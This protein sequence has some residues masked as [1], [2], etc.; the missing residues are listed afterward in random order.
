MTWRFPVARLVGRLIR[1]LA[2]T[3]GLGGTSLPGRVILGIDPDFIKHTIRQFDLVILITGTNGKTTTANLVAEI[4]RRHGDEVIH[5]R[6]GA[7]MLSG[8]ATALLDRPRRKSGR[9]VAV[10]EVDEGNLDLLCQHL[11]PSAVV[12]TNL[13]RDQ[14]DRYWEL[15]RLWQV[16]HDCLLSLPEATL[17]LNADDS[18]VASLGYGHQRVQYY[19][20]NQKPEQKSSIIEPREAHFCPLC[21]APLRFEYF[22]YSHLGQYACTACAY[23][24]PEPNY[25]VI[26]YYIQAGTTSFKLRHP[27]GALSLTTF[28]LGFYNIYN[29]TAAVSLALSFNVPSATITAVV[30]DFL[31]PEGRSEVFYLRGKRCT[32]FLTKNPSGLTE[33]LKTI[34]PKTTLGFLFAINDLAADGRDVSWLWD[35]DYTHLN[36]HPTFPIVCAGLR[37][38]DMAL[39]LKYNGIDP[40]R[41]KIQENRL[42]SILELLNEPVD[43]LAILC[44][45][46]NLAPYRKL[47]CKLGDKHETIHLPSVSRSA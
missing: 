4:L 30:E 44:T 22:Q 26:S 37:A 10:L 38:G 47:L 20:V 19:G 43:E 5:N 13:L 12:V 35:V 24:R 36:E 39:C 27:T 46:T 1:F 31:P 34:N 8:I 45:Y 32:L 6:E 40:K 23:T 14:L 42:K 15:Q 25:C 9:S 29:V 7:N 3:L 18:L 11:K 2:Q 21:E 17:I 33:V 41:I 16:I 28:L